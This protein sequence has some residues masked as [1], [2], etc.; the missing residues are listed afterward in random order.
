MLSADYQ[1]GDFLPNLGS[2]TWLVMITGA[3][4]GNGYKGAKSVLEV[5]F[6]LDS[7]SVALGQDSAVLC[8]SGEELVTGS[9]CGGSQS[10]VLSR[11]PQSSLGSGKTG[12]L[13][14]V[15]LCPLQVHM[16]NL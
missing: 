7:A 10:Q 5:T 2:R 12:P 16:L 4:I 1:E 6:V 11:M 8:I 14:W 15:E 13:L 3:F 9:E